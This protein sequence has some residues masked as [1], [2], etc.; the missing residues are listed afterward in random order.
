MKRGRRFGREGSVDVDERSCRGGS[1]AHGC[2][3]VS[4]IHFELLVKSFMTLRV[5]GH[6]YRSRIPR[7][8]YPEKNT[9]DGKRNVSG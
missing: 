4:S 1:S 7:D 6:C 8:F 2:E 5:W 9:I 3:K